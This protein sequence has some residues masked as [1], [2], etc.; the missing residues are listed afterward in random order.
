MWAGME[1]KLHKEYQPKN[2]EELKDSL[3]QIRHSI[4]ISTLHKMFDGF[5]ARMQKVVDLDDDYVSM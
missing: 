5:D 3:E 2:V 1:G 4:P